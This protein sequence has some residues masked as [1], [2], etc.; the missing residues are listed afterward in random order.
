MPHYVS[1]NNWQFHCL[2]FLLP[3]HLKSEQRKS[4]VS[5]RLDL[6]KF[7]ATSNWSKIHFTITDRH[8]N[9]LKCYCLLQFIKALFTVTV[10]QSSQPS[11]V[12]D[13]SKQSRVVRTVRCHPLSSPVVVHPFHP[14]HSM[15]SSAESCHAGGGGTKAMLLQHYSDA[16]G[17]RPGLRCLRY[18]PASTQSTDS[19]GVCDSTTTTHQYTLS[20]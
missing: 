18:G 20:A 15:P 6:F 3:G 5:Q 14:P 7:M 4:P 2:T 11:Q 12:S 17:D 19:G 13:Y 9:S 1:P 10:S 8:H 16:S